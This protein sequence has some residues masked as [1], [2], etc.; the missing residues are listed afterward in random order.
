MILYNENKCIAFYEKYSAGIDWRVD[1]ERTTRTTTRI[2][3]S[4][5]AVGMI[6]YRGFI[7]PKIFRNLKNVEFHVEVFSRTSYC[8]HATASL[9]AQL[10]N[11]L[12]CLWEVLIDTRRGDYDLRGKD[13]Q[14]VI[15][16]PGELDG[17]HGSRFLAE[18]LNP[19]I[20]VSPLQ[21]LVKGGN[22]AL[23]LKGKFGK[24]WQD[25]FKDFMDC[26]GFS[27][28]E[29]EEVES[30]REI[31]MELIIA[32]LWNDDGLYSEFGDFD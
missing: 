19:I 17:L 12:C 8:D 24:G 27:T 21:D 18:M 22:I 9:G 10:R 6:K 28:T 4:G 20:V 5:R 23:K 7:Y 13:W 1:E 15:H 26:R 2:L 16:C 29:L 25:T 11:H 32:F 3:R 31:P 30:P 14:V